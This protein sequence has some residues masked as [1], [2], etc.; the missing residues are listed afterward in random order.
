[1]KTN[2]I[3]GSFI[4]ELFAAGE[5]LSEWHLVAHDDVRAYIIYLPTQIGPVFIAWPKRD[6]PVNASFIASLRTLDVG[7]IARERLENLVSA[8]SKLSLKLFYL[9]HHHGVADALGRR[10]DCADRFTL[11][12]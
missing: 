12:I 2:A 7:A 4:I 9:S 11:P 6:S 3:L 10:H 5:P 8:W 1:V